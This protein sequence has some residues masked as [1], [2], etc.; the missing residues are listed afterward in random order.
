MINCIGRVI[1]PSAN[2]VPSVPQKE[3]APL[4]PISWMLFNTI[5][6]LDE[7]YCSILPNLNNGEKIVIP[8]ILATISSPK[9]PARAAPKTLKS[10]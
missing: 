6:I 3:A 7:E 10:F 5:L 4:C 8:V 1:Y 2:A 9:K